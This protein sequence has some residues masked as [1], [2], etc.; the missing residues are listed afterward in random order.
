MKTEFGEK[1][2]NYKI[3]RIGETDAKISFAENAVEVE[4]GRWQADVYEITTKYTQNLSE[5][6]EKNLD[7]WLSRAKENDAKEPVATTEQRI[8]DL[9]T[10]VKGTPSYGELLEAVNILLGE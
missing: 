4:E 6:I 5:R 9:E 2:Q 10:L 1:P 7:V 3:E 8:A